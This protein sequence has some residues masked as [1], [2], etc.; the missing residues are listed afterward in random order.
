MSR[1]TREGPRGNQPDDGDCVVCGDPAG[2][3]DAPT[4][5]P[6]CR[7]CATIRCDGGQEIRP[8]RRRVTSSI[9]FGGA[10]N[11]YVS[12]P[13]DD[14]NHLSGEVS[15][16]VSGASSDYP[17]P[18]RLQREIEAAVL[19]VLD[20]YAERVGEDVDRGDGPVTDGGQPAAGTGGGRHA[21]AMAG[22]TT[23]ERTYAH[24]CDEV[25]STVYAPRRKCPLECYRDDQEDDR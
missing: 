24:Y 20:T 1:T 3:I 5:Q 14:T 17:H 15:I 12:T 19:D 2:G 11:N 23:P 21:P 22:S 10:S 4:R 7:K 25:G 8:G 16:K 18:T 6:I 13:G 9:N